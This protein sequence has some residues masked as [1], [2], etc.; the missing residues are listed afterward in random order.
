MYP[1]T[2]YNIQPTIL[3]PISYVCLFCLYIFLSLRPDSR[4]AVL[5][6]VLD[7]SVIQIATFQNIF[8]I[9]V[10]SN[11]NWWRVSALIVPCFWRGVNV[12]IQKNLM[13]QFFLQLSD[14]VRYYD[15]LNQLQTLKKVL[16][17]NS[18][19]WRTVYCIMYVASKQ[20][21]IGTLNTIAQHSL[22]TVLQ[23]CGLNYFRNC[24][25]SHFW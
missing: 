3:F 23:A 16:F 22:K 9:L 24:L 1:V 17:Q 12:S 8:G 11:C 14:F 15:T 25:T 21:S 13:P 18:L 10:Y 7:T 20:Q 5:Y 4:E 19:D 2:Y 6:R